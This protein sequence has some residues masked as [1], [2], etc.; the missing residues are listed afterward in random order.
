MFTGVFALLQAYA[1]LIF[2]RSYMT[3][4]EFKSFFLLAVGVAAA[5]IFVA[6][7]VLTWAGNAISIH[8]HT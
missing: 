4:S 7:V 1:A 8:I 6:V 2:L 5:I 3:K